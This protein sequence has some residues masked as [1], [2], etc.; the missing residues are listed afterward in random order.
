M[1]KARDLAN[2]AAAFS[3]VS[4][5]EL[6]YVDGVTSA[7]QTQ[8]D[9]KIAKTLTSTTGDIIY[10]S[11]ANTPA[12]LGI[13]SAAQVLSVA[14]GIP[15][16]S[17]LTAAAQ[18]FSLLNSGG[19]AL[20]GSATVTVSGIS[21]MNQLLI[22]LDLASADGATGPGFGFRFNTDTG[23]NYSRL[24]GY[25]LGGGTVGPRTTAS[26]TYAGG[27]DFASNANSA[28][29]G[30][31]MLFGCNSAGIKTYSSMFTTDAAGGANNSNVSTSGIYSG[32]STISSVSAYVTAGSWDAGRIYIYGSA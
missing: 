32:S 8:L 29:W 13:G 31:L 16:W 19:T 17:T 9:A 22:I 11:A 6:G 14:S 2:S 4:A 7:I 27:A 12:R 20:T 5:T 15:S 1:T 18:N 26:G 30:G 21:G 25:V 24:G 3:A 10:A 28:A 23:S